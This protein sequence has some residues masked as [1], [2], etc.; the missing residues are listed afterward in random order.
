[1][2]IKIYTSPGCIYCRT[3]KEYLK[4]HNIAFEEVDVVSDERA[5]REMVQ[6]TGQMGVPVVEING[7]IIVGF[8]KEKIDKILKIEES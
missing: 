6:K 8:D 1:M 4:K 2:P 3:L 7:E 5:L